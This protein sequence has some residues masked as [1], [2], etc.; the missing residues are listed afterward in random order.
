MIV[1][2]YV[3]AGLNFC[4]A[5]LMLF[6]ALNYK[7]VIYLIYQAQ[8]Q[9]AVLLNTQSLKSY[10]AGSQLSQHEKDN[11]K[12]VELIKHYSVDSLGYKPTQNFTTVY[13]QRSSATLWVITACKP[14]AMEAYEWTFPIVGTVSYKGFFKKELATKEYNH[15]IAGN[16]DV[17]MRSVTAWSTLGWFKDPLL[18]STLKGSKG[19]LCNLLFHELFHATYYAAGKVDFN[20]NI[21]SFVAHKATLLFLKNDTAEL[22]TYQ[23]NY[24]DNIIFNKYMLQK[25]DF[26]KAYYKT[27]Q[28]K[29]NRYE[30][31]LSAIYRIADSIKFLPLANKKRYLARKKDILK[32]KNAYFVDFQQYDSM[33]DSLEQVFNKI[34]A[35]NIKKLVRDLRLE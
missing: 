29:N 34:Y 14:Y 8:G 21:A 12:L 1:F 2:R 30:L 25:T 23:A 19:G 3:R 26:L 24:D 35:G 22:K 9:A 5:L 10:E 27:T 7:T 4:F 17:D 28:H 15:L 33:Q 6:C 20:E 11:I 18:S 13:D 31:K 16:Y 32:F